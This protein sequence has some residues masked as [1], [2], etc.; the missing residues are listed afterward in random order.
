[1]VRL[2][3]VV[4]RAVG[5]L[6]LSPEETEAQAGGRVSG[7]AGCLQESCHVSPEFSGIDARVRNSL[8]LSRV[9]LSTKL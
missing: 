3:H 1:M 5:R 4:P 7:H 6:A 9:F 2:G 8:T